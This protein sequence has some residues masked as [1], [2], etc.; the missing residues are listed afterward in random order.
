M[1]KVAVTLT[2]SKG[3]VHRENEKYSLGDGHCLFPFKIKGKETE[4]T[5]CIKKGDDKICATKLSKKGE[6]YYNNIDIKNLDEEVSCDPN[7]FELGNHQ[8][9]AMRV[10]LQSMAHCATL[11]MLAEDLHAIDGQCPW[12][13]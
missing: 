3:T 2:D 5:E 1:D 7:N 11:L 12:S 6:F 8:T 9:D 13:F 10:V 4:Y